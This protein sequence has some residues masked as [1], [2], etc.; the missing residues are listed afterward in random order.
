M[1]NELHNTVTA[2]TWDSNSGTL[3]EL[4]TITT[5]PRDF[6]GQTYTAEVQVHP[7]GKFLYGSNRGHDSIAAFTVDQSTGRLTP[8]EYEPTQGKTPRNFGIDPTGRYLLAENQASDTIVVF[9]ID[10]R[11]GALESTGNVVEVASPVCVKMLAI[12]GPAGGS[13]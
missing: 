11:T 7:S 13:D 3:S 4:H 5:L 6:D 12:A 8:I 9:R 2:F 10:Q 1:I